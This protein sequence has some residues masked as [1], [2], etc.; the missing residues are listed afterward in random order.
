MSESKGSVSAPDFPANVDWLNTDQPLT[1]GA[2]RGKVVLLDFWTYC[3]INCMHVIPDLKRLEAK[4][5]N[6]L[7]VIGVHSAKFTAESQTENIRQ[8]I[9]R[10]GIEHPV[11][12]DRNMVLWRD[13][14]IRAWPS[15]V[16]ID[17]AGKVVG[18]ASGEGV[19]E[20]FDAAIAR[21]IRAFDK[22]GLI[23]RAPLKLA[24][25]RAKAPR[26]VLSFPG[27]VLADDK[28]SQLFIADSNHNRIIVLSLDDYS[29]KA[30]I[31]SGETGLVD[32]SFEEAA[33]NHPQGMAFDGRVLYVADT[34][35]HAIRAVD[36]QARTVRTIAGTGTQARQSNVAGPGRTTALNSPWDLVL[37]G[38]D[39][40]IAMAGS[41]QIWRMDLK[42][43][44]VEP[45]AGSG[46]E[47]RTDGALKSAALAQPSG[48]TTDG[49][50]LYFADSE[51]SAIRAADLGPSGRVETIVGGELFKFGDV[52]GKGLAVRLQHPLGVVYH[53]GALYVA[54]TYNNKIK[55]VTLDD[56]RAETFLGTGKPGREDGDTPTFD[57]PGGITYAR[58]KLYI[59][60]TNN[61][62]IRVADLETRRVETLEI[63]DADRLWPKPEMP[64]EEEKPVELAAQ[65]V[66]SGNV[67]LLIS[68]ELPDK[69]TLTAG[70]P[71]Q[72]VLRSA[73]GKVLALDGKTE[74]TLAQPT[75]PI[76]VP[77]HA[78][79]GKT[80]LVVEYALYFCKE[81]AESLCYFDGGKLALP[82]EVEIINKGSML[83]VAIS[84]KA[85]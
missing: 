55:R 2:L 15:F 48:L 66:G 43:G 52:D 62:L 76:T 60:D 26:S 9:L 36:S 7:V 69:H 12:N 81:G 23:D 5:A 4:Y 27:K 37:D 85:P 28:T 82:V 68:L 58:G 22:D 19:Y 11:I 10:Y 29:V 64:A 75:F 63:K 21:V 46:R 49:R 42:S 61:S 39:L 79:A 45:Y 54:D 34:E 24:L 1:L 67:D 20:Q 44:R 30:V 77:V 57:E 65:V 32:G 17:P 73:D 80:R 59:A 13:Y 53:D 35:N 6:E 3:C 84:P 50:K 25:E 74:L 41:H 18:Y 72:I 33:F 83:S 16:L 40:Y 51:V 38:G 78:S 31:G 8:A 71:T 70:A 14:G 56:Q 47:D